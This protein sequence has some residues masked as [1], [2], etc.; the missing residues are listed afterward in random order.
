[1]RVRLL[2]LALPLMAVFACAGPAAAC[3]TV[4]VYQDNPGASLPALNRSVGAGISV[5]STYLTAGQPLAQTVIETA[6]RERASLLVTWQPDSGRATV[7]QSGYRLKD[8]ARG[9]YDASL[10]ALVAQ[11][12]TV[13]RGA[14][15]R[16]M[17]EMNT[18]WYTWSGTVNGNKPAEYVK[19]WD[20][21]R[22]AVRSAPGGAKVKLLWAP[23]AWSIPNTTA[24]ELEAYFPGATEVDLVGASGYN[25][26]DQGP[27]SWTEPE[28]LFASAYQLIESLTA[29]PFWLAETG[30]TGV[31]GDEAEWIRTLA[32]LQST[33]MPEL[34]GIVWY[35]V[36]DP[37]G[38][39]Q[40]RGKPVTSAFRS[41]LK[42]ACR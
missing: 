25:F 37:T 6:N 22:R 9:R 40:L 20:R 5:I 34:A 38:D 33:A 11:L 1:M 26:G 12:R 19:A 21:V 13:K 3:V 7:N 14:V 8:V 39:F 29:K 24:N 18:P 42:E 17:P 32:T 16:P 36:N 41:L 28:D 27:L 35:D 10:K 30:S 2:G 23:Y 4:G 15:L 31:G